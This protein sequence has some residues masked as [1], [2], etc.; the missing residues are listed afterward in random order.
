M[1]GRLGVATEEAGHELTRFAR[2]VVVG[3]LGWL[4]ERTRPIVIVA[5]ASRERLVRGASA[6]E[7][8]EE[9]VVIVRSHMDER[10]TRVCRTDKEHVLLSSVDC[11][12]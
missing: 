9:V 1:L 11:A 8:T 10:S 6:A 7:K 2:G 4:H 5:G 3:R 12:F